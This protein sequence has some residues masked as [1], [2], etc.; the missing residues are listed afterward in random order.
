MNRTLATA[1][2]C[3]ILLA[4]CDSADPNGDPPPELV[5]AGII[6]A[7]QGAFGSDDGGVRVFRIDGT[8]AA[9]YS[10]LFVQS[11][12]L[13]GERLFVTS[14]DRIDVLAVG[15]LTLAGQVTD[16]PNPRY[17]S[18]SAT[19]G[20]VSN[21]YVETPVPGDGALTRFNLTTLAAEPPAAVGGNPEGTALV[22]ARLYVA[23]YDFGTGNTVTVLN[24]ASLQEIER[25]EVNCDGPRML[26]VDR[27]HDLQVVCEGNVWGNPATNGA[28]V[29]LDGATGAVI[30]R[31]DLPTPLTTAS[32][33][34]VASYVDES[35]EIYAIYDE[36]RLVYRFDTGA[37]TLS[38]TLDV[39]GAPLNGVDYDP[40][41]EYLYLARLHPTDPFT[42]QGTLTVHTRQGALVDTFPNAGVVPTHVVVFAEEAE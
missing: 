24:P 29:T 28:I 38:A 31:T 19:H 11:V 30:A 8:V 6:V 2:L 42:A 26:F 3:V 18:F 32:L 17:M 25:I 13:H 1:L 33:G 37:N 39:G 21:L 4:G 15:D 16:V 27:Q 22:G 5:T 35:A 41:R 9:G 12:A 10:D 40:R 14:T 7:S 34:Q 20:F 36:G 23:N